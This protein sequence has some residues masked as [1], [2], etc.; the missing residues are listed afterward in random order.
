[1]ANDSNARFSEFDR[2]MMLRALECAKRGTGNVSPNPLVGCVLTNSSGEIIGE[3]AYLQF[4]G[5]HAEPNA[6]RDAES[7]AYSVQG[8]TVYVTLEPH[9]FRGKTP[10]CS[11]LLVEKKVARCVI[12]TPDPNPQVSGKGIEE[13]RAAGIAV[14]L[15]LLE[16]ESKDLNR[17]FFKHIVTQQPYV[18]LKLAMSLDGRT[19]LQ[20]GESKWITSEA[21][22]AKVH[23]LRAEHD[24]V[25]IGTKTA[26]K[27]NPALTVRH[28]RG[29][30]P[31]RIV[32]DTRLELPS[33][34]TVLNDEERAR[35]ILVTSANAIAD[36]GKPF[37]ERGVELLAVATSNG[38]I[39]LPALFNTLGR[40]GIISILAEAGPI[41]AQSLIGSQLLDE[42]QL[43]Y[44]PLL[45]GSDAQAAIGPLKLNSLA[46]APHLKLL[47]LERVEGTDDVLL[48][49]QQL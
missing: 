14:E 43:F 15:G 10:P 26:L 1:M 25:L 17:F 42:L 11:T 12:A 16:E 3:G 20:N 45:F 28:V 38:R 8:A 32:L 22:R 48:R 35:T 40:R 4:G 6:I 9:S 31:W 33:S 34:L 18:T 41:L 27:D 2:Q 7:R 23:A 44:G 13:L 30:Q 47:N 37:A 36:R 46:Q 49:F 21:S 24:A 5:L 29:R 39:D 19:A